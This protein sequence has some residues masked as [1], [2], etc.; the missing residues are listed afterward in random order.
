MH[1]FIDCYNHYQST[2]ITKR[3]TQHVVYSFMTVIMRNISKVHFN[4]YLT[5]LFLTLDLEN[6]NVVSYLK[7]SHT[8]QL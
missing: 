5:I 2:F 8:L 4:Y 7:L 1:C 3:K 6:F